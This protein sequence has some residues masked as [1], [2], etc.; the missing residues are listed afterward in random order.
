MIGKII[1]TLIEIDGSEGLIETKSGICYRVYLTPHILS[2][3]PPSE[4]AI[5]TYLQIRDDQHVLFGFDTKES[6][7]MFQ[8]LLTVDGVGPKTAHNLLSRITA[9]AIVR[10]V[11]QKDIE[12]FTNVPGLGK[13]T[14][15]KILLEL[16][17]KMKA[18]LDISSLID[19]PINTDALETLIALG[20]RNHEAR[21][22][23]KNVDT[24]LPVE[25]QVKQALQ[26]K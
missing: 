19:T 16:S 13:K 17:S 4:I 9:S 12:P 23:L 25:M 10:A 20:Y 1:G 5:Y 14:A 7:Q 3:I 18:E 2:R 8:M 26:K 11:H 21:V 15:Q 22:M 6:Y 24:T